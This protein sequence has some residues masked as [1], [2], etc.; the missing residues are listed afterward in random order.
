[1]AEARNGGWSRD[2][3]TSSRKAR[4]KAERRDTLTA[5]HGAAFASMSA[6]ASATLIMHR[7]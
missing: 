4:A 1:M 7:P 6:R 5:L 2:A 3:I